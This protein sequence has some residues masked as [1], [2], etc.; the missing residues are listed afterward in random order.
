VHDPCAPT[1]LLALPHDVQDGGLSIGAGPYSAV[2]SRDG[3]KVYVSNQLGQSVSVISTATDTVTATITG[4][5]PGPTGM[6]LS[7]DGTKLYIADQSQTTSVTIASTVTNTALTTIP[8]IAGTFPLAV[9]VTPDGSK[10]YVATQSNN[11]FVID[12]GTNA[13]TVVSGPDNDSTDVTISPDGT[14]VYIADATGVFVASTATNT[15]THVSTAAQSLNLALTPDGSLLYVG[16]G[17][18]SQLFTMSTATNLVTG[19]F[20]TS[21]NNN[22][23][24]ALNAPF[25]MTSGPA[26]NTPFGSTTPYVATLTIPGG[27]TATG[28]VTFCDTTGGACSA[29]TGPNIIGTV[30]LTNASNN[31]ASLVPATPLSIG[32]H[33]IIANYAG[34]ASHGA[35]TTFNAVVTNIQASNTTTSYTLTPGGGPATAPPATIVYSQAISGTATVTAQGGGGTPT[36]AVQFAVDGT[37]VGSPAGLT[38]GSTAPTSLSSSLSIGN[39]T[40]SAAYTPAVG[41]GWNAS[42]GNNGGATAIVVNAASTTVGAPALSAGAGTVTPTFTIDVTGAAPAT[43]NPTSGSVTL[44]D[45]PPGNLG[46]SAQVGVGNLAGLGPNPNRATIQSSALSTSGHTIWAAF[47]GSTQ[48]L[49][50]N[51]AGISFTVTPGTAVIPTLSEWGLGVFSIALIAAALWLLRKPA[52]SAAGYRRSDWRLRSLPP[53]LEFSAP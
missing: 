26:G 1:T 14:K 50:G 20:S 42:T 3:T 39:H 35:S 46:A 27:G 36:G 51:S 17:N 8:G 11:F 43:A 38:G 18:T 23:G 29:V 33:T 49:S 34:D 22:A 41:T 31:V 10:F 24:I 30:T 9:A 45:G 48:F 25:S 47:A 19:P 37:S 7:P 4:A 16:A 44:Y 13:R 15:G 12:A 2:V 32:S 28:T 40:V 52:G 5:G 6:A 21:G 53:R